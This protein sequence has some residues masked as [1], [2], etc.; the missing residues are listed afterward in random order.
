MSRKKSTE[1]LD[2]EIAKTKS[3]MT[4]LQDKYDRLADKLKELQEQ[5]QRI[6]ADT[7]VEACLKSGKSFD[8]LM[9]FLQPQGF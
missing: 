6:E 5:R 2:A 4:K 8:E 9:T 3:D 1:A 7:I